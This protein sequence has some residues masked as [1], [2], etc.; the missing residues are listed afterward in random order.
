MAAVELELT[1]IKGD[2]VDDVCK[3]LVRIIS[4]GDTEEFMDRLSSIRVE[5]D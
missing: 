4:R 2:T 1:G 5:V 3:E